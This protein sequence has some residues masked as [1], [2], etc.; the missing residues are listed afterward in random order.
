MGTNKQFSFQ[1]DDYKGG[2]RA[3]YEICYGQME[4]NDN[5]E[6]IHL[7]PE[8]FPQLHGIQCSTFN[9]ASTVVAVSSYKLGRKSVHYQNVFLFQSIRLLLVIF[10]TFFSFVLSVI[11]EFIRFLTSQK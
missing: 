3:L 11:F 9:A 1:Q 7:S 8:V 5:H 6:S 4:C 2:Q 10:S